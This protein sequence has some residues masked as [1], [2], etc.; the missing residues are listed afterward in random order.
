MTHCH[1]FVASRIPHSLSFRLSASPDTLEGHA[2]VARVRATDYG[3]LLYHLGTLVHTKL[4]QRSGAGSFERAMLDFAYWQSA[5][6]TTPTL[7]TSRQYRFV[8]W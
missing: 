7:T 8:T 6:E 3:E 5:A 4:V 2:L 1:L